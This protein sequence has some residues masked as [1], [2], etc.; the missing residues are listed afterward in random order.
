MLPRLAIRMMREVDPR[1]LAKFAC[2]FGWKGWRAVRRFER[3][4]RRGEP[5]FPAFLMISL[6]DRCNLRCQGCWVTPADPPRALSVDELDRLIAAANAHG[7]CFFGLLGGEPLLHPHLWDVIARHPD[8]YFQVFTNGT[9]LTPEVAERMRRLGNVTPLIS[10]EGR[11]AVG[12]VRRGGDGVYRQAL[13]ALSAC[14]QARLVTGVATSLCRSNF[15]D[16]A[17]EAFLREM[18]ARGVHY[19]WYYIYRPAGPDPHPE[20]ALREEDILSLRRFLLKVRPRLPLVVVDAYWDHAGRAVCAGAMGLSHHIG[21]GGDLEFCPP[22]QFAVENLRGAVGDPTALFR[23]SAFLREFRGFAAGATR[24]CVLL[25]KPEALCAF[26]AAHPARDTSGRAAA[27]AEL[28]ALSPC[29]GH[30]LPGQEMPE[31]H[32]FYRLAKRYSFFGFGAYG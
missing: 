9:L 26:L 28:A 22:I 23:D 27:P 2:T 19:L 31:T 24:G 25:E 4:M 5:F 32:W 7:S 6:T 11:E 3:R 10:I 30:H 14:R 16:L 13:D 18:I 8:C 15:A 20:L 21:P 12:D 29:P 1:L 17:N